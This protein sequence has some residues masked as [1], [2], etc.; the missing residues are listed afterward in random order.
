M[1][2][3]SLAGKILTYWGV[4]R[5]MPQFQVTSRATVLSTGVMSLPTAC[6]H[7]GHGKKGSAKQLACGEM[8]KDNVTLE[9]LYIASE[10]RE[11]ISST[12]HVRIC[13]CM[14]NSCQSVFIDW[15]IFRPNFPWIRLP[16]ERHDQ[17]HET[18]FDAI[19]SMSRNCLSFT[20][21]EV[22]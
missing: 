10:D 17:S 11:H 2:E 18:K 19:A 5:L 8:M 9:H 15:F 12:M 13:N 14:L 20:K 21:E 6:P 4:H 1:C 16:W 7:K 3:L 22:F